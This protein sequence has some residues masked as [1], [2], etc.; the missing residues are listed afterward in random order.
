MHKK[1]EL[2]KYQ[3]KLKSKEYRA[4]LKAKLVNEL[5]A[6]VKQE[7]EG[8]YKQKLEKKLRRTLTAEIKTELNALGANKM[9]MEKK[10]VTATPSVQQNSAANQT[11]SFMLSPKNQKEADQESSK[12]KSTGNGKTRT[13]RK[14]DSPAAQFALQEAENEAATAATT[15][16]EYAQ[17]ELDV[18]EGRNSGSDKQA[19]FD[20][21]GQNAYW[22]QQES[23]KLK[24]EVAANE[25]R[26]V[27]RHQAQ[28]AVQD[29]R[30]KVLSPG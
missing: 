4:Q 14:I 22:N 20:W 28:A 30:Y 27:V 15:T 23:M 17:K 11:K 29:E 3:E 19:K 6:Q 26:A 12:V 18:Q 21:N 8:P 25:A 2:E 7:V 16:A 13:F 1:R 9:A 10:P 5:K 24:K